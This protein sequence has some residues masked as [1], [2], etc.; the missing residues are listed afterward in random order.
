MF[1]VIA[2]LTKRCSGAIARTIGAGAIVVCH[3]QCDR[4]L[5]IAKMELRVATCNRNIA[6]GEERA[7]TNGI[8]GSRGFSLCGGKAVVC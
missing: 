6:T 2:D 3:A 7:E 4:C 8:G 1:A 5:T